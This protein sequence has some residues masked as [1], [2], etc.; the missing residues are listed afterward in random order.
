MSIF[1]EF[2]DLLSN[3]K[4]RVD[5]DIHDV[6]KHIESAFQHI[7]ASHVEDIV[8]HAVVA[9]L[10]AATVRIDNIANSVRANLADTAL[11]IAVEAVSKAARKKTS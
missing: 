7:H 5:G 8:K 10:H 2:Q 3:V 1:A 4:G 6:V 11:D 9:D